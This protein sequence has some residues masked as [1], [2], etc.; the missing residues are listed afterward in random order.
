MTSSTPLPGPSPSGS[1]A[2]RT[3]RARWILPIEGEPIPDGVLTVVDGRI[4]S[5]EPGRGR[6]VDRDFGNAAILPG[7]V[8]AHTHLEL[9]TLEP[10]PEPNADA[11]ARAG[12]GP[13]PP[14]NQVAWLKRVIA[15]RRAAGSAAAEALAATAAEN[16]ERLI[17]SGTT[18]V[19]DLT[20]AGASWRAIAEA[21]LR[22]V[23]YAEIL[24]LKPE[25]AKATNLAAW[26]WIASIEPADQVRANCRVGLAPHA[27]YSTAGWLYE[28]SAESRLPLTT[29]LAEMPEEREL[30]ESRTGP[31]RGFLEEIGAWDD[32]WTP[33]GRSPGDYIRRERLREADWIVAHGH[34]FRPEE[35]WMFLPG[36]APK[37]Q[38]VALAYCPR[39]R[40][41]FG[42]PRNPW[43]EI[44]NRGGVACVGSDSLAS[45][46]SL[47]VLDEIRFLRATEPGA[48]GRLL[49]TMATLFGAWA[50]RADTVTGSLRPGKSADFAV[51]ALPEGEGP[52][53]PHDWI[54]ESEGPVI[55]AAFEGRVRDVPPPPAS[56]AAGG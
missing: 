31:L 29:H 23:V 21:P 8:N 45:A 30:L 16:V 40:A 19:A 53:D 15:Q 25:R 17:D 54:V 20:T 13:G 37:G 3:Y 10:E 2:P 39:T 38:R 44:L 1:A 7:F 11:P 14:E 55:A 24:G 33:L 5:V 18:L 36:S 28:R 41:R 27:P 26:E 4:R 42:H 51:V 49:L 32:D 50:L 43:L 52:D 9:R 22:G 12:S 48:G 46:P 47:S 35:L 34:D 56:R 6:S